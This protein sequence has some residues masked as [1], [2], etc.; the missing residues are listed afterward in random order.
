[1]TIRV[2]ESRE[3]VEYDEHITLVPV[4]CKELEFDIFDISEGSLPPI[5]LPSA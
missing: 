1:M 5:T 3:R 2:K 4:D